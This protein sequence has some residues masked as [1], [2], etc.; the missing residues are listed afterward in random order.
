MT[1]ADRPDGR[2]QAVLLAAA[3]VALALAPV[4]MAYLQLGYAADVAASEGYTAPTRDAERSLALAVHDASENATGEHRWAR[5]A[6]AARSV[7]S[8]LGPR[9]EG[10]EAARV[11]AGTAYRISYNASAARAYATEAC[12]S[13]PARQFGPCVADGGVVLQGRAG[14]SHV[15]AVAFDLH[16][17]GERR[18]V[19]ETVVVHPVRGVVRR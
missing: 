18:T 6:D 3:V 12:P 7:R 19:S 5:R 8:S 11:E 17:V 13:G 14:E 4:L 10:L 9:I 16:V 15:L 1:R 2:A